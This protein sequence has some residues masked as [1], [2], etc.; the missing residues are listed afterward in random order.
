MLGPNESRDS[1]RC[2]ISCL[3][4]FHE[5]CGLVFGRD[6]MHLP[7]G[8]V[9]FPGSKV[10]ILAQVRDGPRCRRLVSL[11][12]QLVHE[13]LRRVGRDD[14]CPL[15][16][17]ESHLQV[18]H[19]RYGLI[20]DAFNG[21]E[22][23]ELICGCDGGLQST[24]SVG[25]EFPRQPLGRRCGKRLRLARKDCQF[26]SFHRVFNRMHTRSLTR[27][28]DCPSAYGHTG[29]PVTL[30]PMSQVLI[31]GMSGAGKTTVLRELSKRGYRTIDTDY[32]DW[33][34]PDG[35]W[36]EPRMSA[37]LASDSSL[38]VSGTVENQGRFYDRFAA[39]VLL[40]APV[41]VLIERVSV[42]ANNPYGNSEADKSVIRRYVLDVEPLL[43][44]G[45]TLELDGR[46]PVSE[47]A[48]VVERLIAAADQI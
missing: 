46:R 37:L 8:N 25:F 23:I 38:V 17:S 32:D 31:T 9:Q 16:V 26:R 3:K 34:L 40:S 30:A 44:N 28:A 24:E 27:D 20:G 1:A 19:E 12:S 43:R 36:D 48:D 6:F 4:N 15:R 35:T 42:R 47:L 18:G 7:P 33:V 21:V 45:A 29:A 41:E 5:E 22:E 11:V 13:F 14:C 39:V 10:I 2:R